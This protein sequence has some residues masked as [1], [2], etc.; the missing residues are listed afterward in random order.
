MRGA[1]QALKALAEELNSQPLP[2]VQ[3]RPGL[4]LP[5]DGTLLVPNVQYGG[6]DSD[7]CDVADGDSPN[8]MAVDATPAPAELPP[9]P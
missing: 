1:L 9:G 8:A 2:D 7:D 5:P 4:P 6:G 3:G